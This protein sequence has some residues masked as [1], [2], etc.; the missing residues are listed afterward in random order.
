[1]VLRVHGMDEVGVR[2]PIGPPDSTSN[3]FRGGCLGAS[4]LGRRGKKE[5]MG[6]NGLEK[7]SESFFFRSSLIFITIFDNVVLVFSP[8]VG[9]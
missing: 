4:L 2:F 7:N 3:F 8:I 6:M 9:L 1:M 5:W